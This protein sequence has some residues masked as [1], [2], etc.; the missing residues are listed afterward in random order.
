MSPIIYE[1]R[2]SK[3]WHD[4]FRYELVGREEVDGQETVR[5]FLVDD[6]AV[7]RGR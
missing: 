4:Y 5:E 7:A 1:V 2:L 6:R 3:S